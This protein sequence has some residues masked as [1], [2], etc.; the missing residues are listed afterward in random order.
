MNGADMI[1]KLTQALDHIIFKC[2]TPCTEAW[3][4]SREQASFTLKIVSSSKFH[5]PEG[6]EQLSPVYWV[7][8]EGEMGGP[9][10]I[11]L[12]HTAIVTQDIQKLT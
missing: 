12:Q 11:E 3:V 9:M 5:M 7:E 10:E 8:S 1:H 6:V 4:V 2:R